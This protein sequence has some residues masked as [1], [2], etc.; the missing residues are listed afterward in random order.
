MDALIL[1][2]STG[3]GHNAAGEAIREELKSRGHQVSM[4]DPYSLI[5]SGLASGI[6]N[7]YIKLVQ[8]SPKLFGFV[9]SL[10]E[11]YRRLP[12][13]SPVYFIN[14]KPARVLEEYLK[15]HPVDVIIMPHLFP[16]EMVT[17]LKN[18]RI[19]L[20]TTVFVATDYACIPFT[21]ETDCDY[22]VIPHSELAGDFTKKGIPAEKLLPFG[23]PVRKMFSKK[24]TKE[25]AKGKLGLSPGIEYFL[26]AGGSIGAGEL[27]KAVKILYR[28][29]GD[30]QKLII[31]CGNNKKVYSRMKRHYGKK[32]IVLQKTDKM[33]LYMQAS[34]LFLS[35]PGGLSS[36]EAAV[37]G[38][39]MLH[40]GPIP[41]C[42]TKNRRFFMNHGISIPLK[43]INRH[44]LKR[45]MK[46]L[47]R[48]RGENG[49]RIRN[50][51]PV[52][53]KDARER[54]CDW[55][56]ETVQQRHPANDLW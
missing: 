8:M 11:L 15:K 30:R 31:I 23:I 47:D 52:I 29:I 33:A 36:T 21:E 40:F 4:F 53:P 35:K 19:K 1:S 45:V 6:G 37:A 2:C 10:G 43:K 42:E 50:S 18:Q 25:Q 14:R 48:G 9:Y 38:V 34:D 54:I 44:S 16:A 22:Y 7:V 32:S 56:E 41:G 55:L 12:F 49:L 51:N 20:P 46:R 39:P 3:G 27:Q 5:S 24:C 26:I 13:R 17:Q 28:L